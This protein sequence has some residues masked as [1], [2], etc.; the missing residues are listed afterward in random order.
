[1]DGL[2]GIIPGSCVAYKEQD[3]QLSMFPQ[4]V[5]SSLAPPV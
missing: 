5:Q 3:Q 2:K 4:P 1:M